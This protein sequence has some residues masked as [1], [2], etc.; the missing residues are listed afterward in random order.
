MDKVECLGP[1]VENTGAYIF[2]GSSRTS[3]SGL[4]RDPWLS[5]EVEGGGEEKKRRKTHAPVTGK[6]FVFQDFFRC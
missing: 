5:G 4:P 1:H 2:R 3:V 6:C